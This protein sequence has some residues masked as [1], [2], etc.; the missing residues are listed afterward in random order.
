MTRSIPL[1]VL[2]CLAASAAY[3]QAPADPSAVRCDAVLTAAEAAA[4]VG[5]GYAGPAVDEPRPGFTRCEWQGTDSNFG[6]TFASLKTLAD[7]GTTAD[8]AFEG[9]VS[10]VEAGTN[11]RELVPDVGVRT[12]IVPVGDDALLVV[13]QRADGVARM[14]VYKVDRDKA[15]ALARAIAAP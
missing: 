3:A 5:E 13:V 10:A 2:V 1:A 8:K 4:I 6:F 11:T 15:L 12:A 9:D 7:D 14:I